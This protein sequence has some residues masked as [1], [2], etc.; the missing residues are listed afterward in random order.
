MVES[1]VCFPFFWRFFIIDFRAASS[2][3]YVSVWKSIKSTNYII[4]MIIQRVTSV[5]HP[6]KKILVKN[7]YNTFF[8]QNTQPKKQ[9]QTRDLVRGS[10]IHFYHLFLSIHSKSSKSFILISVVSA[11][12]SAC[13]EVYLQKSQQDG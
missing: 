2:V 10:V 4:V 8:P 11:D 12:R 7:V 3:L 5:N 1:V 6:K 13:K 9:R